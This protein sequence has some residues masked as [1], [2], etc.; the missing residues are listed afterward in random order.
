ME[1][2]N[3]NDNEK[4]NQANENQ[5]CPKS[6]LTKSINVNPEILKKVPDQ[7]ANS[8][9]DEELRPSLLSPPPAP[10][11]TFK[12]I[13]NS[14]PSLFTIPSNQSLSSTQPQKIPPPNR[15]IQ[16]SSLSGSFPSVASFLWPD[17]KSNNKASASLTAVVA[18]PIT[19]T[20]ESFTIEKK[21]VDSLSEQIKHDTDKQSKPAPIQ[22]SELSLPERPKKKHSPPPPLKSTSLFKAPATKPTKANPNSPFSQDTR[23]FS[24]YGGIKSEPS[25]SGKEL[26]TINSLPNSPPTDTSNTTPPRALSP[27]ASLSKMVEDKIPKRYPNDPN[28]ED[29][30]RRNSSGLSNLALQSISNLAKQRAVP[31]PRTTSPLPQEAPK[32]SESPP[33][34]S[35]NNLSSLESESLVSESNSLRSQSGFNESNT[36]LKP[37]PN[38]MKLFR[39]RS[40]SHG[41]N[42]DL[43]RPRHSLRNSSLFLRMGSR[44]SSHGGVSSQS[45]SNYASDIGEDLD[46]F[47]TESPNLIIL[48]PQGNS[49]LLFPGTEYEESVKGFDPGEE[50]L[51]LPDFKKKIEE[52]L[53]K[54]KAELDEYLR[55][56]LKEWTKGTDYFLI[57]HDYGMRSMSYPPSVLA[58]GQT[59]LMNRLVQISKEILAQSFCS[60]QKPNVC[61]N[62]INKLQ[63]LMEDQRRMAMAHVDFGNS[64][65]QL[66]YAFARTSRLVEDLHTSENNQ[67]TLF[68]YESQFSPSAPPSPSPLR[69]SYSFTTEENALQKSYSQ[70]VSVSSG[71]NDSM[72]LLPPGSPDTPGTRSSPL[73]RAMSS[74]HVVTKPSESKLIR[75]LSHSPDVRRS[76][77]LPPIK[78]ALANTSLPVNISHS[79]PSQDLIKSHNSSEKNTPSPSNS[80]PTK[81]R[82]T[83]R[84]SQ[85][86][87]SVLG[88]IKSY[89]KSSNLPGDPSK[90]ASPESQLHESSPELP[91]TRFSSVSMLHNRSIS[92]DSPPR[93]KSSMSSSPMLA[94]PL[95]PLSLPSPLGTSQPKPIVCRIC[96]KQ[97]DSASFSSHIQQCS[98]V[99]SFESQFKDCRSKFRIVNNKCSEHLE[100]QP[101]A[102][103][104]SEKNQFVSNLQKLSLKCLQLNVD[105]FGISACVFKYEKYKERA[106]QDIRELEA[107][108]HDTDFLIELEK[109]LVSAIDIRLNLLK[110]CP[111]LEI[112][113]K[114]Q[115]GSDFSLPAQTP[116]SGAVSA[117][118]T[119]GTSPKES[120]FERS[121]SAIKKRGHRRSSS[122]LSQPINLPISGT[123]HFMNLMMGI[124]KKN[125][126]K[127]PTLEITAPST[128]PQ[129]S[130]P[131]ISDFDIIKPISRGAFGKVYL[132]TKKTTNDLFAI[133]VI[134]KSDIVRKNMVQ[135]IMTER[136]V[137]S[138]ASSPSVVSMFYAFHSKNYLFLVME[139]MIGGDLSSLLQ[140]FGN[141]THEMCLFYGA[142]IVQS[143]DELHRNN[144]IHRDLKPDNMLLDGDGHLKLTDFGLSRINVNDDAITNPPKLKKIRKRAKNN[145]DLH[146]HL[147]KEL[148]SM[149]SATQDNH[150]R[151]PV[152]GTPDY[153]AP[154]LLL[155]QRHDGGVDLWALGVCLFEFYVGYP[156]FMDDTPQAIFNN[157]LQRNI[158][159]PPEP[160]EPDAK[161]LISALLTTD[162]EK[163]IKISQIKR[164]PYFKD[165]DWENLRRQQAPF[166]PNP[167]DILDTSYFDNRN[168][169]P[170]IKRYDMDNEFEKELMDEIQTPTPP[171]GSLQTTTTST[172]PNTDG[173]F[174]GFEYKN[175]PVL[176]EYNKEMSNITKWL[177]QSAQTQQLDPDTEA[178]LPRSPLPN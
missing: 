171:S 159:W 165:V 16:T 56:M 40:S 13:L 140:G 105:H 33:T 65:Y 114:L 49:K 123:K 43:P 178:D 145:K 55:T 116:G 15:H 166:K 109:L 118:G 1:S 148:N 149:E 18:G 92:V 95:S 136:S 113:N 32:G 27:S 117:A 175:V 68:A 96:E 50:P 51:N 45:S 99:Q 41:S 78:T 9:Q 133:K 25:S 57:P 83:H 152:L 74:S 6:N 71:N 106:K 47:D 20:P 72:Y 104:L 87:Y 120:F 125:F 130:V 14:D 12:P 90:I 103:H 37:L 89:L 146:L 170:D 82:P 134:R 24:M 132:A 174:D 54:S 131:S 29:I 110:T 3:T 46:N 144:V 7:K 122:G 69:K 155:G 126:R 31:I 142:E 59:M 164:H 98:L 48:T 94:S 151:R 86:V 167:S 66:L 26:S 62:L 10:P 102:S 17:S 162:P 8:D 176:S 168:Q 44:T 157:I 81:S 2:S 172:H 169:R 53:E 64:I 160:I 76:L 91:P 63:E 21:L 4:L 111:E 67:S 60:L 154:E 39:M 42:G 97:F 153:L 156:P 52:E 107:M 11:P 58:S 35:S 135:Q 38:P 61:S 150:S 88:N 30:K 5:Q 137:M 19:A 147:R 163:R 34:N 100:K 79:A 121:I 173:Y 158:Q 177:E 75:Q 128:N 139:Y 108:Q 93:Y 36:F 112:Q 84:T 28:P 138:L 73:I 141:F 124:L 115:P 161:D 127:T 77:P 70:P 22:K 85:S 80:S 101:A 119:P 143:L 23:P 129:P